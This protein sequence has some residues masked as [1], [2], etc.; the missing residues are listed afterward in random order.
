MCERGSFINFIEKNVIGRPEA[1][2]FDGRYYD[3][4]YF[5]S[6]AEQLTVRAR[7]WS[8]YCDF[9]GEWQVLSRKGDCLN[10]FYLEDNCCRDSIPYSAEI[11]ENLWRA[12]DWGKIPKSKISE[13]KQVIKED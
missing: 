13:I 5:R 1:I 12:I 11:P 10:L 4:S 9:E 7:G 2:I 8:I 3:W 6:V